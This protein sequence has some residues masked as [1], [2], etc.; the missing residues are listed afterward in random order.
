MAVSGSSEGWTIQWYRAGTLGNEE[1]MAELVSAVGRLP[2]WT[3]PRKEGAAQRD[4]AFA[5]DLPE[6]VARNERERAGALRTQV[7]T[8]FANVAQAVE[9]GGVDVRG[10]SGRHLVAFGTVRPAVDEDV[11][12]W[13]RQRRIRDAHVASPAAAVANLYLACCP[14]ELVG[15]KMRIVIVQ[16]RASTTAV[17]MDGWRLVDFVEYQMLEGQSLDAF[18]VNDWIDYVRQRHPSTRVEPEPLV[19]SAGPVPGFA[20]WNPFASDGPVAAA[21][22]GT[23]EELSGEM[24]FAAIAFGMALQGGN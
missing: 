6:G 18:L 16:G 10:P 11:R 23:I 2:F 5:A 7:E 4:F 13:R 1:R 3:T 15:D 17:V 20:T 9:F 14:P 19:V 21:Q 8:R 22:A 12:Y 24:G